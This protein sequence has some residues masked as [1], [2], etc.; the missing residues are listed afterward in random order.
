MFDVIL[1][2]LI[3]FSSTTT[4]QLFQKSIEANVDKRM[5]TTYGPPAG[6]K[7]MIFID[8]VNIPSYN[9]WGDQ[10]TNE[11]LRQ[12]IEMGGFYSLEKPGDFSTI[13]DVQYLGTYI[14]MIS[15]FNINS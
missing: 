15:I 12:L 6:K 11:L 3:I 2:I 7:M 1:K 9:D 10:V 5:G 8:D 13:V 4:P 14:T